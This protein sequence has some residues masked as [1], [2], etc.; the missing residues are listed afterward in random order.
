MARSRQEHS[1]PEL[2]HLQGGNCVI[3]HFKTM[4]W[5]LGPG[6]EQGQQLADRQA[7]VTEHAHRGTSKYND[8]SMAFK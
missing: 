1:V 2:T 7:G 4:R 5:S 8:I 6:N 3:S